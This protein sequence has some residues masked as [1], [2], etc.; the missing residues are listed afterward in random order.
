MA[1]TRINTTVIAEIEA[2]LE[3]VGMGI[4]TISE[5]DLMVEADETVLADHYT[6]KENRANR[7]RQTKAAK[8]RRKAMAEYSAEWIN[9]K[10]GNV[11][12]V[13]ERIE[14]KGRKVYS[15]SDRYAPIEEAAEKINI[16]DLIGDADPGWES[17]NVC[18]DGFGD[19]VVV[20]FEYPKDDYANP[21]HHETTSTHHFLWTSEV[22]ATL[23]YDHS[24][25]E[26]YPGW[27]HGWMISTVPPMPSGIRQIPWVTPTT[28]S[29][30]V[31]HW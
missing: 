16:F 10:T 7:R 26:W 20:W 21:I 12:S 14:N 5:L 3:S 9:P 30:T 2:A 15:R 24:I 18:V 22:D 1:K 11:H 27:R 19:V 6:A 17:V 28:V 4:N 8:N 25:N 29:F 31:P 23:L 13:G